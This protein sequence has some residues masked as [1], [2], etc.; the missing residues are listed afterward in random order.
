MASV[1]MCKDKCR[2]ESGH[3]RLNYG[4]LQHI[5]RGEMEGI[6]S[7][8]GTSSCFIM[9]TAS[10]M[11]SKSGMEMH[12]SVRTVISDRLMEGQCLNPTL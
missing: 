8:T 4:S 3:P 6:V 1:G 2:W 5:C 12:S 9:N 7:D 11:E 10:R